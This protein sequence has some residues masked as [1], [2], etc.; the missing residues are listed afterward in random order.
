MEESDILYEDNDVCILKPDSDRGIIIFTA[1]KSEN[2]CEE[3]LLSYNELRKRH[4]ELGLKDRDHI[5]KDPNHDNLIF[6]RAPYHKDTSSFESSYDGKSP[7]K[8]VSAG[9]KVLV[10]I[11]IDPE[12]TFVYSSETRALG[13]YQNLLNSRKPLLEYLDIIDSHPKNIVYPNKLCGNIINYTKKIFPS[14]HT[15]MYP[16]KDYLPIERMAEVIVNIPYIPKEWFVGCY[17]Y[18]AEGGKRKRK[19]KKYKNKKN[20][21]TRKVKRF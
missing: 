14:N 2:M 20:K 16:F 15:C 3:G 5:V 9:Q 21:K 10:T 12:K 11:R 6:F 4:P 1:G 8:F 19:T 7:E 18:K 17:I 13:T